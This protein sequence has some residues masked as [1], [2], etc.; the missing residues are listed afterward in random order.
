M[1]TTLRIRIRRI[2]YPAEGTSVKKTVNSAPPKNPGLTLCCQTIKNVLR[3]P[4]FESKLDD[5]S[6]FIHLS[7]CDQS[8]LPQAPQDGQHNP[9]E[10]PP[11]LRPGTRPEHRFLSSKKPADRS[12]LAGTPWEAVGLEY[13]ISC[14]HGI[15]NFIFMAEILGNHD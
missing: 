1:S 15:W 12:S 4:G 10:H 7:P 5:L 9:A 2:A 6:L 3:P 14:P 13:D 8:G 11:A